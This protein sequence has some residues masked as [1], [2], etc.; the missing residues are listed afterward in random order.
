MSVYLA[1]AKPIVAAVCCSVSFA[2]MNSGHAFDSDT[3]KND[4]KVRE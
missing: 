2:K 4:R 3:M 1:T